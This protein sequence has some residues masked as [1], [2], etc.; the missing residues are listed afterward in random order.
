MKQ[1]PQH[2]YPGS[3]ID[4]RLFFD[5]F[6]LQRDFLKNKQKK[7]FGVKTIIYFLMEVWAAVKSGGQ[8]PLAYT[9]RQIIFAMFIQ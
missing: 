5:I 3:F 4:I 8:L 6:H 1:E 2:R 7:P 9:F